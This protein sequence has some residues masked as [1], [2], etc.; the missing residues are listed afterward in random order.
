MSAS[1][2]GSPGPLP[3]RG[4]G[5]E[6]VRWRGA[7]TVHVLPLGDVVVHDEGDDWGRSCACLPTARLEGAG[8]LA[9]HH[10]LDGRELAE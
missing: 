3:D 4:H 8:V 1:S 6:A 2:G 10:S 7:T 9:V 5:W